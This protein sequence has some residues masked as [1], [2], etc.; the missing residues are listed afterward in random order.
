MSERFQA[1]SRFG[2]ILL[3]SGVTHRHM[4][5]LLFASFV[6][7]AL[8]TFDAFGTPYVLSESIGV[9]IAQ[10]GAV[11]GRL[12]V[13]TEIVLLMV[14][15]P[16]GALSDRVGRRAVY[17][18]GFLCLGISYLLFPYAESVSEL[19][20]YR[21]MYSLGLA[22]V[23]GMLATVIADYAVPEHRGRMVGLTGMLN[24]LGIVMSALLLARLP[25]LFVSYGH[26]NYT[27]GQYTLFVVAGLCFLSAVV[28]SRGLKPGA[29]AQQAE[30]LPFRE[31]ISP[32]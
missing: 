12:N 14:F 6:S 2:F 28:V 22:G 5:V 13:Y 27:A 24:G 11:I 20:V 16:F 1:P 29:A 10:Q 23:T 9:P 8:A 3:E 31:L 21:I 19:A 7:I 17:A 15:T 18:F 25:S 26:D 30:H 4:W 32:T